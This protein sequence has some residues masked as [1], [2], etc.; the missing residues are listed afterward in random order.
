MSLSDKVWYYGIEQPL[1]SI[2]LLERPYA[3]FV[4]F[5]LAAYGCFL[6][7]KPKGLYTKE[8]EEKT[9]KLLDPLNEN[10]VILNAKATAALIGMTSIILI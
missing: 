9:T 7:F 6:Y 1:H 10:A 4:V 8:G 5:T 2:G 3:R